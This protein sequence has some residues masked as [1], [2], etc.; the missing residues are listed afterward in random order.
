MKRYTVCFCEYSFSKTKSIEVDARS[1][2]EAYDNAVYGIIPE[3]F[4]FVPWGA[5]VEG[6]ETKNGTY[7]YFT[8]NCYGY[9]Y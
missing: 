2:A 7:H 1:S 5:Y 8:K 3:Q 9:P 6:Y 4:G